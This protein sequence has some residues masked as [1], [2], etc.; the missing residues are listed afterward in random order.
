MTSLS[1]SSSE[2]HQSLVDALVKRFGS[3]VLNT[4]QFRGD[5]W[6]LVSAAALP[7]I[8]TYLRDTPEFQMNFVSDIVGVDMLGRSHPR[9]EIIYNLYSMFNFKR[10]FIKVAVDEGQAVPSVT[11]VFAG[12]N[13]PEREIFDMFGVE[14]TG[15]PDL[16]RILMPDDWVGYP[17]RKDFPLGGEE[18]EF[19][20]DT[21]GP[22][23]SEE[24][25]PYPGSSFFGITGSS[26]REK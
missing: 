24:Q 4:S 2:F 17:L 5:Q 11:T 18:I 13:F 1:Q 25:Q 10:V 19:A 12:A 20:Q 3:A 21:H 26:E 6:L 8:L 16:T 7:D 15:H 9:F 23:T 22:S 14:F